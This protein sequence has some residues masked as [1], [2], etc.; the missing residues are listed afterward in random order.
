[1]YVTYRTAAGG[2]ANGAA[3]QI[4]DASGGA[5]GGIVPTVIEL[6]GDVSGGIIGWMYVDGGNA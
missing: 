3:Q 5:A 2:A 1:M 4:E 6:V